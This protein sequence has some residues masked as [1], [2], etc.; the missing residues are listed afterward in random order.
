MSFYLA[1][2]LG[3]LASGHCAGMC[4]G[5]LG[6]LSQGNTAPV[7]TPWQNQLHLCVMNLG[8]ISTYGIAGAILGWFGAELGLLFDIPQWSFWLRN[9]MAGLMILI[10]LQLILQQEQ[11]FKHLEKWS[12]PLWRKLQPHW[13]SG[14]KN[15]HLLYSYKIGLLWG[16]LPCGLVYSVLLTATSSGSSFN[17]SVTMLGFG[18]GTLPA[19][20][21][22]GNAFWAYKRFIS[23]QY[24][25]LAAGVVLISSGLF[26]FSAPLLVQHDAIKTHPLFIGLSHCIN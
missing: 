1:L 5:L 20:V 18:L 4:G 23:Q 10:G 26:I 14:N 9:V 24:H 15:H 6:A 16:M 17:G 3:L 19:L 21:L 8:R 11:V 7:R 2:L 22:S 25:R 12:L 13:L